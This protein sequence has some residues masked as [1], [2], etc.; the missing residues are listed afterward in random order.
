MTMAFQL[1]KGL[2]LPRVLPR[3][4]KAQNGA[5]RR[6]G[7][8]WQGRTGVWFYKRPDGKVIRIEPPNKPGEEPDKSGTA[9]TQESQGESRSK[10]T[11]PLKIAESRNMGLE[12]L[13]KLCL[14]TLSKLNQL[15]AKQGL[16]TLGFPDLRLKVVH[17]QEVV[18]SKPVTDEMLP[19][20]RTLAKRL[21]FYDPEYATD[22][23]PVLLASDGKTV[24]DGNHRAAAY[25]LAGLD[26][27]LV[28]VPRSASDEV[29]E[30]QTAQAVEEE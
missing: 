5:L 25:Q 3:H 26:E 30:E 7:E 21:Q 18:L 13:R 8:T 11:K 4:V 22:Y 29:E 19:K 14:F 6:P 9:P 15:R 12:S 28:L 1:H 27:M 10:D 17:P 24:V 20:V 2:A 16:D 23:A